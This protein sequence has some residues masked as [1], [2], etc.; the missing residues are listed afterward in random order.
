[1]NYL[2]SI[3]FVFLFAFSAYGEDVDS[4]IKNLEDTLKSQEKAISEQQRVIEELK[5]EKAQGQAGKNSGGSGGLFGGSALAN[6]NISLVLDTF[7]YN[8]NLSSSG[9]E[10]RTIPGYINAGIEKTKGFNLESAELFI[11]APVD[12]YFNVY[13]T[14]PVTDEGIELE[15]AYFLTT[16]LP[17]G[18]QVK[19]GKFK[20]GFGR[21]NGQH[22]HA[23]D[24]ADSPLIYRAFIGD[25]GV[26]EKGVQLTYLPQL[27]FYMQL[28]IEVLQG[29]NELLFGA[30]ARSGPHAYT[31]F[32]KASFDVG[33]FSTVLLGPSVMTGKTK[34][35]TIADDTEFTGDSTLYGFEVTYKWK[36]SKTRSFILQSEYFLRDQKGDLTDTS[37]D[38]TDTLKRSQDG[39]YIQGVYQIGR[40]RLGARYDVLDLVRDEYRLGGVE[41][42]FGRR[43]W[44][45]TADAEFN[46]TEFSRIRLQYNYDRSGRDGKTNNEVIVQLTFG[47]GAHAAHP[48]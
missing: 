30:D 3:L 46:P 8:S 41:Q 35:S 6:P 7:F 43:P 15:E 29:E 39:A 27:P 33:D 10:G 32:A 14:M 12:P 38:T 24:F 1:M 45:A 36:P 26:T 17:A 25:E 47:I 48:F 40:C 2:L 13:A 20:S 9:L 19:G 37:L 21:I 11:Y 28:G 23:W 34:T 44:R 18:I 42:A 16:S 5:A 22:P 4:R 31:A